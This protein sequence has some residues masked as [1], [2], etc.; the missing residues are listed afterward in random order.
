MHINAKRLKKHAQQ[1]QPA[2]SDLTA[3]IMQYIPDETPIERRIEYNEHGEQVYIMRYADGR[4][5]E[6]NA[7]LFE[8]AASEEV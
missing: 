5:I 6:S 4:E 1:M 8:P 2:Q 7:P 3:Q